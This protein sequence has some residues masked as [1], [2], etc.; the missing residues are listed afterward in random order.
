V[1]VVSSLLNINSGSQ[2]A[3]AN[4]YGRTTVQAG[5]LVNHSGVYIANPTISGGGAITNFTGLRIEAL[6]AAITNRFA[7][8][9]EGA[10]TI[11]L[12][13]EV[14]LRQGVSPALAGGT[15]AAIYYDGSEI[16]AGSGGAAY[17]YWPIVWR[18]SAT[19]DFPST[20]AQQWSD[21]TITVT[22]AVAG[23]PCYLGATATA[24][25]SG[26]SF[27]CFVSSAN[28]VTVR[29]I[30]HTAGAVDPSSQ[31]YTVVVYK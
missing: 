7:I 22:G 19:L 30:N 11:S 10:E 27:T 31:S 18:A 14:R 17:G 5:T 25:T 24:M 21:L 23:K 20:P 28:T 29:H 26:T 2:T 9:T 6:D 8:Y 13:G 15:E 4:F 1:G 16:R 12:G 3:S